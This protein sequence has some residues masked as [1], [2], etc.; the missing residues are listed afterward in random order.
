MHGSKILCRHTPRQEISRQPS[1]E[2]HDIDLQRKRDRARFMFIE[3][4]G[5]SRNYSLTTTRAAIYVFQ[6]YG[7]RCEGGFPIRAELLAKWLRV[8]RPT[9]YRV[10]ADLVSKGALCRVKGGVYRFAESLTQR[11]TL[12]PCREERKIQRFR[13]DSE[14]RRSPSDSQLSQ[15]LK[16][17]TDREDKRRDASKRRRA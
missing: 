12:N 10:L 13:T 2:R 4:V 1:D 14:I 17:S 3:H 5:K 9:T 15:A 7:T 8:S 6:L 16:E 11:E